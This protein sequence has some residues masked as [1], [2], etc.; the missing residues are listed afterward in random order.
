MR[1]LLLEILDL[2]DLRSASTGEVRVCRRGGMQEIRIVLVVGNTLELNVTAYGFVTR[3]HV[4]AWNP[5]LL[6]ASLRRSFAA[7]VAATV[8]QP[9]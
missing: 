3:A 4:I 2:A 6:V 7:G 8:L 1:K 9:L 5:T